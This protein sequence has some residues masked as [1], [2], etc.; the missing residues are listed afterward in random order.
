MAKRKTAKRTLVNT[1]MPL[2]RVQDPFDH[3]EW[4]YELKLDGFR[5]RWLGLTGI[6][7]R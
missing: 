2:V 7:A 6:A 1:P 3:C 4:I 5:A